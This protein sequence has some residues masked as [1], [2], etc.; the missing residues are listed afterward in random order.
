MQSMFVNNEEYRTSNPLQTGL[1][2][3]GHRP[4]LACCLFSKQ[5]FIETQPC[6]FI[7]VL[8]L[9]A[10]HSNIRIEELWQRPYGR[11]GLKYL[12]SGPQQKNYPCYRGK[13][14]E[15]FIQNK[16]RERDKQSK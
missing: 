9:A 12:L 13:E 4:N 2:N 10:S 7:W 5:S 3:F 8:S 15:D 11:Q 16:S 6:L 1:V 14:K